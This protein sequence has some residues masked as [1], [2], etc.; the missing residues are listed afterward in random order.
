MPYVAGQK[1]QADDFGQSSTSAQYQTNADQSIANNTAVELLYNTANRTST[2]VT[3]ATSGSGH[4]FT[5]ERAG[6]WAISVTEQFSAN[7][8]GEREFW[9]ACNGAN[10]MRVRYAGSSASGEAYTISK[11]LPYAENDVIIVW[12]V[13]TSGGALN[14]L[15]TAGSN[16]G[17]IDLCWLG[18]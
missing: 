8:T 4:S 6:L 15:N 5:L 9:V 12:C 18:G 10:F 13:Q 2:L 7:A 1:V 17:R 3:R 11:I 14:R 16:N